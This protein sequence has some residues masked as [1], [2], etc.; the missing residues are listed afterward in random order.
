MMEAHDAQRRTLLRGAL[1]AGVS[2]MFFG[3]K[4]KQKERAA[5]IQPNPSPSGGAPAESGQ[6]VK[7]SQA[8]AKYQAKPKG[9]PKCGNCANFIAETNSC[10]IV[11]GQVSPEGWCT[12]WVAS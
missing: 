8:N 11:E 5:G 7:M 4:A 2:L 9:D 10:K 12:L 3:C 1:A 6:G